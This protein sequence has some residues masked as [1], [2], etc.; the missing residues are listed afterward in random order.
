MCPIPLAPV[1]GLPAVVV[2]PTTVAGTAAGAAIGGAITAIPVRSPEAQPVSPLVR[3]SVRATTRAPIEVDLPSIDEAAITEQTDTTLTQWEES[4]PVGQA[5]ATAVRDVV[6][7]APGIDQQA[8]D[9]ATAQPGGQQVVDA[10]DGAL[11]QFGRGSAGVAA[12]LVSGAV[13]AGVT[14]A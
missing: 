3:H 2:V 11:A 6:E 8:R 12:Q 9:W 5:A 14:Q 4:G 10:I 1:P 7:A 13:G